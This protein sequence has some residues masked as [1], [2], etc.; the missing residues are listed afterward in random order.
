MSYSRNNEIYNKIFFYRKENT[1][2]FQKKGEKSEILK[3]KK[4]EILDY[5]DRNTANK[6]VIFLIHKMFFH[7]IT[8]VSRLAC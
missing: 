1:R 8:R 5:S 2:N 3:K 6:K 4:G 7:L